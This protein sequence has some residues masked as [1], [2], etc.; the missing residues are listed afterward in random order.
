MTPKRQ[1]KR[2]VDSDG[3]SGPTPAEQPDVSPARRWRGFILSRLIGTAVSPI[4]GLFASIP[5]AFGSLFLI[6]GW[7]AGPQR[8]ID[9]ARLRPYTARTEGRLVE[10]WLALD[11]DPA[12]MGKYRLWRPQAKA[13]QCAVVEFDPGWGDARGGP[14]RRAFCGSRLQFNDSYAFA[15]FHEISKNVPFGWPRDA[16]GFA[17]PEVRLSAVARDWLAAHPEPDPMPLDPPTANALASFRLDHDTPIDLAIAGWR[18]PAIRIP[19]L[20]D[21]RNPQGALPAGF[22]NEQRDLPPHVLLYGVFALLAALG[23]LPWLEGMAFLLGAMPRWAF[24]FVALLPLVALP[25]WSEQMPHVISG[26][27]ARMGEIVTLMLDDLDRT[28]VLVSSP[29][30]QALLARGERLAWHL[31]QSL[32]AGTLGRFRFTPPN[33]PP[34][35]DAEAMRLL[36]DTVTTQE[37]S[38]PASEQA[39]LF[40]RLRVEKEGQLAGAGPAFLEAARQAAVAPDAEPAVK[41]AAA[42]FLAAYGHYFPPYPELTPAPTAA[43]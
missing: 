14:I 9:A 7:R 8:L 15:D 22:V 24:W 4:T 31:D 12:A 43:R 20:F 28:G 35:S 18:N 33:A 5:I 21:P 30:D 37:R 11:F 2:P 42:S 13:T 38:L 36:V 17:V 26:L 29:P 3:S 10:S 23:L 40:D 1:R 34:Q 25:W 32:Y 39:D 27:N 41:K 16:N 6:V 19:L